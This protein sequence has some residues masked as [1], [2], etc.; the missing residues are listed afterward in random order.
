MVSI[1]A[2]VPFVLLLVAIAVIPLISSRWWGRYYPLAAALLA[3]PIL[4]AYLFLARDLGRIGLVL[5]EYFSFICLIGSLYVIAGG[6]RLRVVGTPRP[7]FN[8][9]F[10]FFGAVV[11][12]IIGTTGASM[13]L[14]RPFLNTNRHR[15]APY[16]VV[17][18]I[19]V[20]ANIGGALTPIGDPPL[21]LGYINGVPFFWVVGRVWYIWLAALALVLGAFYYFDAR[22]RAGRSGHSRRIAISFQ[23]RRNL[24][25]LAIVLIA[26]FAHSPVRELLMIA[27]AAASY[28]FARKDVHRRNQFS[29]K[30]VIEVAVLFAAIFVT[31]APVLQLLEVNATRLGLKS[32]GDFFWM[33]GSLSSVLDSAPTYRTFLEV[34]L[35]RY[36]NSMPI[37]LA[38]H[39]EIVKATSLGTVFFGAMTYIGNGPNFMVRS[40]AEHRRLKVPHFFGYMCHYSLPI[41]LPVF[42]VVWL[43]LLVTH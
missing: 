25:L 32:A 15:F 27:A 38:T 34:A 13:L 39:S 33:S 40:I 21:F 28:F 16:L 18:F 19:F 22:N 42:V 2:A 9:L 24:L 20:V 11:S 4:L 36:G 43:L 6:I 3:L 23:G 41:L 26:V 31:M 7:A 12:N 10:L 1:W 37:L 14:I 5:R 17:F 30:P 29:F 35:G 8:V